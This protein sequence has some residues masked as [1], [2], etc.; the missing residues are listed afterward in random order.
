MRRVM[1]RM[2][3]V[4]GG[5]LTPTLKL[6][7]KMIYQKYKERIEGL[8]LKNGVGYDERPPQTAEGGDS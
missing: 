2:I 8:Y 5:E 6:K 7:R 4:E 3:S 1:L